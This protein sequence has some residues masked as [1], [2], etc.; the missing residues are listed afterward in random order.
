M[1]A[2][3]ERKGYTS[4]IFL[5]RVLGNSRTLSAGSGARTTLAGE[6]GAGSISGTMDAEPGVGGVTVFGVLASGVLFA[7]MS[8][9]GV[10]AFEFHKMKGPTASCKRRLSCSCGQQQL[11]ERL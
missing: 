4:H 1:P 7:P 8:M 10:D 2:G 11:S 3:S 6:D 5:T 9:G